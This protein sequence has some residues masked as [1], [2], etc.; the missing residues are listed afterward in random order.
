[1]PAAAIE[2]GCVDWVL[3]LDKIGEVITNLVIYGQIEGS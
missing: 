3:P 2:T 1:M